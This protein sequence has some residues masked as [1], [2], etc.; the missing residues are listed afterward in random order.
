MQWCT[1]REN[2]NWMLGINSS[3]MLH[4]RLPRVHYIRD[5]SAI[6]MEWKAA[7]C[8]KFFRIL[9][10]VLIPL[11]IHVLDPWSDWLLVKHTIW[12]TG[13]A[14]TYYSAFIRSE[15][16]TIQCNKRWK[17]MKT[18]CR[19]YSRFY[20]VWEA[21][22]TVKMKIFMWRILVGHFT[23]GAFLSKHGLEGVR[24]PHSLH[25]PTTL[26]HLDT[27]NK[28]LFH[29]KSSAPIFSWTFCKTRLRLDIDA[30]PPLDRSAL[31][32]LIDSL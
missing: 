28:N 17:L 25:F 2:G 20:A 26:E 4:C 8:G 10:P 23:L 3:L 24:C 29:N 27:Q 13:K 15:D 21:S 6:E 31:T 12:W 18:Q 1:I 16:I 7:L 22:F 9:V 14:S 30:M 19:W 5:C 11:S 32:S